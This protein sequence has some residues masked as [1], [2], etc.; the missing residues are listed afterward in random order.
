MSRWFL[1]PGINFPPARAG[2]RNF[3]HRG[4]LPGDSKETQRRAEES[5]GSGLWRCVQPRL[6]GIAACRTDAGAFPR[7]IHLAFP[8]RASACP[9]THPAGCLCDGNC[10]RRRQPEEN[11]L[12]ESGIAR[13]DASDRARAVVHVEL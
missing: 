11:E 10:V 9:S 12:T 8:L 4:T 5:I 1:R 7:S 6:T 3:S 13:C 2:E